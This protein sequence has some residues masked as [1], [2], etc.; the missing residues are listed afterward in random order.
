[1]FLFTKLQMNIEFWRG[2]QNKGLPLA[3]IVLF[4]KPRFEVSNQIDHKR[5]N[6]PFRNRETPAFSS[7]PAESHHLVGRVETTIFVQVPLGP[8][9]VRVGRPHVRVPQRG[10]QVDLQVGCHGDTVA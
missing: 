1:M 6:P 2:V 10:P 5:Q 4:L 3:K 7:A 9:T 8:E